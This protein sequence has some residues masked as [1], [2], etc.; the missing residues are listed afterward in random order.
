MIKTLEAESSYEPS[1]RSRNWLK[2]K[3]D[4][5]SGLGD[6]IDLV[7]IGGYTGRGKRTG[8]FGGYL[9]A[10]YEPDSESYQP[11]CKL[12]TGFSEI[13]L[14]TFAKSLGSLQ[15]PSPPSYYQ[16]EGLPKPDVW[17]EAAQVWEVKAADFSL[18]PIYSAARGLVEEGKGISLRFPRFIRIRE[19]KKP[20]DAS[21]CEQLAE[22]YKSQI[23]VKMSATSEAAEE[24]YY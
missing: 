16:I 14:E 4:Y 20:E 15:I 3:K 23:V 8:V 12:G 5:L 17:F 9:L 19:D 2:V 18:S 10:C 7:V 1:K 24:E 21:T 13:D 22:M 6:S 11:V